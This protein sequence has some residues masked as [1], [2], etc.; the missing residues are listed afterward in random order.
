MKSDIAMKSNLSLDDGEYEKETVISVS[1]V[2]LKNIILSSEETKR[3]NKLK[4]CIATKFKVITTKISFFKFR[5]N[6][7]RPDLLFLMKS[8]VKSKLF[9]LIFINIYR[10]ETF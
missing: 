1:K 9:Q 8:F 5:L 2:A 10:E 7:N 6:L 3:L 4:E